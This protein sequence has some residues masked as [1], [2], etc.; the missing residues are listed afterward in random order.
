MSHALPPSEVPP[1]VPARMLNEHAY[2]PRLAY[3]EWVQGDF[4]DSVDTVDGRYQHRRVDRQH[5]A[6][7]D[8][9]ALADASEHEQ[10]H[11]RSVML[12]APVVGLVAR[13]DL[14]EATGTVVTPVDYKRGVPPDVAE[15][16]WEPERVQLCAQALIL[17]E[18]GYT[19]AEGV[20]YFVAAKR[21]VQVVFDEPL[22]ARTLELLDGL[23]RSAAGASIPPPLKDSPKC[24]RCSLVGICLPDEVN[25][26]RIRDR[27]GNDVDD[28]NDD[29]GREPDGVRRLLPAR[30]DALPLY[31]QEPGAYVGKRGEE[32]TVKPRD[33]SPVGVRLAE[34]SQVSLFGGVQMSTQ[35]VQAVLGRGLPICFFSHGGWFYGLATG[36][37]HKNV[38]LRRIQYRTAEN[39]RAALLLACRF[40]A[41]KIRNCRTL[42]RRNGD[43]PD[44]DLDRLK[45]FSD[46]CATVP[47]AASLLGVEGSAARVY[48]AHF[49][50]LVQP[51]DADLKP[52]LDF[53]GRNRRPPRDPLNALLSFVYALLV[54]DVTITLLAV[55][56]DPLLG[57][58]HRPR[59]GRPAL[60]LDLMEEFRPLIADSVV[61]TAVNTGVVR[62]TDFVRRAGAVS[63]TDAGR[64]RLLRSYERRMDELVTHP[65]F[66]YRISYR[67]VLEVQARLL[68]RYLGGEI[69]EYPGFTTR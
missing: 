56:F 1:L 12:S 20:L 43:V 33:G 4:A 44:A 42:L 39:D 66:G 3:L 69:P 10:V 5:G 34:T 52:G 2:C 21:R 6:L 40:I 47:V 9:K 16:A 23:R 32:L 14:V 26:L 27:D 63:L 8:A 35:A 59:Y 19:V 49:P 55:G 31:V 11:A 15:G 53:D 58:F 13:I 28:D 51:V 64:S 62:A 30:D 60:A 67:R 57:F 36:M 18:N 38:E 54:K 24:P 17:E 65:L 22:R 29:Q 25:Y 45:Q 68:A 37:T 61:L 50:R 48:Y 41:A 7:P 46:D